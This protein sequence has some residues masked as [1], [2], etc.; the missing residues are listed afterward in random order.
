MRLITQPPIVTRVLGRS[1][2]YG[3]AGT[4]PAFASGEEGDTNN[5]TVEVTFSLDVFAS[6]YA[7]G[8][9]IKQNGVA[10]TINSATRQ[11]DHAIVFF[12]VAEDIDINDV[13]TFEYD[14]DFGD[15]ESEVDG[16]DMLDVSA[17]ATTN[18]VGSHFYFD[19]EWCSGHLLH[20]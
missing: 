10:M 6:D 11:S 3:A 16:T 18:Y 4:P 13:I 7:A 19:E 14:D 8:V 20:L 17:Q 15:F 9:T 2:A 12:V 5:N 1:R